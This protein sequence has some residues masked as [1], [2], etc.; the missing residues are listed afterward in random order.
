MGKITKDD[1]IMIK[2]LREEKKVELSETN[3]R[4]SSESMEQNQLGQA[5][6]TN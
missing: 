4:I 5:A 1:S 2:G 6:V 3:T